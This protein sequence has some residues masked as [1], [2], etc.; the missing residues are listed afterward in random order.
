ML[1]AAD[2]R[3][4]SLAR[5]NFSIEEQRRRALFSQVN[6]SSPS[7]LSPEER[8]LVQRDGRQRLRRERVFEREANQT[9]AIFV[10]MLEPA[11][12]WKTQRRWTLAANPVCRVVDRDTP[13]FREINDHIET[14]P[15][16][17]LRAVLLAIRDEYCDVEDALFTQIAQA[18][19]RFADGLLSGQGRTTTE[20][21]SHREKLWSL[22]IERLREYM[23]FLSAA[24]QTLHDAR[25]AKNGPASDFEERL[26]EKLSKSLSDARELLKGLNEEKAGPAADSTKWP[27]RK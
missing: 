3:I 26:G 4:T 7:G 14:L 9:V 21:L 1:S 13:R 5:R 6:T 8:K 23:H 20:F 24:M 2:P 19:R 27:Y 15:P 11:S 16:G 10:S 22:R 18:E 17:E 12:A 25:D